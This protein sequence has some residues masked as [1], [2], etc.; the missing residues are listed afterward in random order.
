[1]FLLFY[2][3]PRCSSYLFV[4]VTSMYMGFCTGI[5]DEN[6]QYL[7]YEHAIIRKINLHV[8]FKATNATTHNRISPGWCVLDKSMKSDNVI[9]IH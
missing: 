4:V 2:F 3:S 1:M 5:V 6:C 7:F 8:L 9:R